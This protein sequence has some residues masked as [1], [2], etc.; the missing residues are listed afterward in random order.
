VTQN[1]LYLTDSRYLTDIDRAVGWHAKQ[2]SGITW[3]HNAQPATL[4]EIISS[5]ASARRQ[6]SDRSDSASRARYGNT[7]SRLLLLGVG[8]SA[9]GAGTVSSSVD[10][11][12]FWNPAGVAH[13]DAAALDATICWHGRRRLP[14]CW[15]PV[16]AH[17]G[18]L[19]SGWLM[20]GNVWA[21]RAA[22]GLSRFNGLR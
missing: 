20:V 5:S 21:R 9:G 7:S 4:E 2:L 10:V 12:G 16:D 1:S 11:S 17:N 14:L 6:Y 3:C 8:G 15:C 18:L 13:A 22:E 19:S